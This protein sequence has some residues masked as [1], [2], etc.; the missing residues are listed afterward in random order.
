MRR[1]AASLQEKQIAHKAQNKKNIKK[2]KGKKFEFI[3]REGEGGGD[4]VIVSPVSA[5]DYPWMRKSF[6]PT[7]LLFT[8]LAYSHLWEP[9][10]FTYGR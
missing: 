2:K 3:Q 9:V 5:G 6:Q 7:G 1:L 10:C 8:M 4:A